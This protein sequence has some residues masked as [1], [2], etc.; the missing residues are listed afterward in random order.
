MGWLGGVIGVTFFADM[1]TSQIF[2]NIKTEGQVFRLAMAYFLIN[3]VEGLLGEAIIILLC[4]NN[5]YLILQP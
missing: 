2:L 3:P 5:L 4:L 1:D